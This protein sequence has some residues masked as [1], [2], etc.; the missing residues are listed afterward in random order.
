MTYREAIEFITRHIIHRFEIPQTLTTDQGTSFISKEVCE[1]VDSY[2]IK[3]L[4]SSPYY[5]QANKQAEASNKT[6]VKLIRKKIEDN[7]RR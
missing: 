5:A 7:P 1:F 4:N 6:L 2:V 3:L